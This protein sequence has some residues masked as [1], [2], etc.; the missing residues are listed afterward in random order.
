MPKIKRKR[1]TK[2]GAKLPPAA[3]VASEDTSSSDDCMDMLEEGLLDESVDFLTALNP[4]VL[5]SLQ[6]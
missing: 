2:E 6:H 3:P 5:D 1:P 4:Y